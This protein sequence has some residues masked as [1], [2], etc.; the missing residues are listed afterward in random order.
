MKVM[1][2]GPI[3]LTKRL[4]NHFE[5]L[6]HEI[7]DATSDANDALNM[8]RKSKAHL[9]LLDPNLS[10]QIAV[11]AAQEGRE[12]FGKS[13]AFISPLDEIVRDVL[14]DLNPVGILPCRPEQ[15]DV[16]ALVAAVRAE[17]EEASVKKRPSASRDPARGS[18]LRIVAALS[19]LLAIT[20]GYFL[21]NGLPVLEGVGGYTAYFVVVML[22]LLSIACLLSV[23]LTMR[24]SLFAA[25]IALVTALPTQQ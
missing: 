23:K 10:F 24:A 22:A 7:S 25:A 2:F 17:R 16:E 15:G 12:S 6:G 4:R 14:L 11:G 3:E 5:S 8:V 21:P 18:S 9:L 19:M 13:I 20:V 1:I